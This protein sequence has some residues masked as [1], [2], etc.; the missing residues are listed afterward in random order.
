MTYPTAQLLAPLERVWLV[1]LVVIV[2]AVAIPAIAWFVAEAL[3]ISDAYVAGLVLATLGA[4]SA[5]ALKGA[6]LAERADLPLVV[7]WSWAC[8]RGPATP[9]TPRTGRRAW[10]LV[11][12]AVGVMST[13]RGQDPS[14]GAL[15]RTTMTGQR[16]WSTHWRLTE[17]SSMLAKPPRPR[18]PSTNTSTSPDLSISTPAADPAATTISTGGGDATPTNASSTMA[19]ASF[20]RSISSGASDADNG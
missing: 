2:N 17:P 5:A 13:L 20:S 4:G 3:P 19:R 12:I 9:S 14:G 6:Q 18:W 8:R 1:I 11:I 7:S 10:C 16:A 15:G